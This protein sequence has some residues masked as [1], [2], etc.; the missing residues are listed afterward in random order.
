[1]VFQF[2]AKSINYLL[3]K[4]GNINYEFLKKNF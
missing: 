2:F 4:D 1:M 3:D